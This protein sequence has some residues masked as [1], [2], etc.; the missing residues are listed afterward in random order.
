MLFAV[1]VRSYIHCRPSPLKE[2]I[3]ASGNGNMNGVD[4][5]GVAQEH[6]D[7]YP[8]PAPLQGCRWVHVQRD[9][10]YIIGWRD[11]PIHQFFLDVSVMR[12][13]CIVELRD[14]CGA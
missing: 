2:E 1:L 13:T 3:D 7:C 11:A 14:R 6:S 4:G 12:L 5:Q 10:S 8:H 9:T